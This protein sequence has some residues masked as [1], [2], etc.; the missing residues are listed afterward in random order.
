MGR[1]CGVE[2]SARKLCA[3]AAGR[4]REELESPL[5]ASAFMQ[6]TPSCGRGELHPIYRPFILSALAATLTVGTAFGA[7]NLF[8]IHGLGRAASFINPSAHATMQL[9]GFLFLFILG[10]AFFAVPRFLGVALQLPR[11]ARASLPLV[12]TFLLLRCVALFLAPGRLSLMLLAV[13]AAALLLAVVAAGT[14]LAF[15]R[16]ASKMPFEP[17]QAGIA[18]GTLLFGLAA[19]ILTAGVLDA[20]LSNDPHR[21]TLWS[22]PAYVSALFGGAYLWVLGMFLRIGPVFL[23]APK[24]STASGY[25]LIAV[26]ANSAL[27]LTASAVLEGPLLQSDLGWLE[28]L[29]T[30]IFAASA[31]AACAVLGPFAKARSATRLLDKTFRRTVQGVFVALGASSA[32]LLWDV[33]PGAGNHLV[34]DAG[35]HTFAVG[36]LLLVT[37]AFATKILPIFAGVEPVWPETRRVLFALIGAG[38]ALRAAQVVAALGGYR[39]LWLSGVSGLVVLVGVVGLSLIV[40]K[41]IWRP[42]TGQPVARPTRLT[43]DINVLAMIQTWPETLEVMVRHGFEPLRV[44]AVRSLLARNITLE[45]ACEIRGVE[46]SALLSELNRAISRSAQ[47]P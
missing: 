31:V 44:A 14:A 11:V 8:V 27:L 22:R 45:V 41:T 19:L 16:R 5:H 6:T 36:F 7:A 17:F 12:W 43:A 4:G 2:P 18:A 26:A 20:A 13:S 35:R 47:S 32:L 46:V 33:A 40:A 28:Q 21:A 15:T 30:L 9:F 25:A 38:V 29:A 42:P 34:A 39:A 24:A 10:V 23:G 3:T 1:V 37:F